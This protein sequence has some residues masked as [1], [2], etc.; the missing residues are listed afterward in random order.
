[1]A[2]YTLINFVKV[3]LVLVMCTTGDDS[4]TGNE[5]TGSSDGSDDLSGGAVAGIVVGI[6]VGLIFVVLL[7]AV[8]VL[9]F[10]HRKQGTTTKYLFPAE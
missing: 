5:N 7:A 3:E 9:Y 2:I 4:A 10:I 6:I 8:G 1:M